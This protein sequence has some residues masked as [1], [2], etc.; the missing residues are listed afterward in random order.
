MLTVGVAGLGRISEQHIKTLAFIDNVKLVAVFDIRKKQVET[1]SRKL[2]VPGYTDIH[3]FF[4]SNL[5]DAVLILTPPETH[6]EIVCEATKRKKAIFCEKPIAHTTEEAEEIASMVESANVPFQCGFTERFNRGYQI[7]HKAV[8]DSLCGQIQCIRTTR[9]VAK[10]VIFDGWIKDP[11]RG[12]GPIIECIIHDIDLSCWMLHD[13]PVEVFASTSEEY[14][15]DASDAQVMMKFSKGAIACFSSSWKLSKSA[16][17]RSTMELLGSKGRLQIT[18][19]SQ[20]WVDIQSDT[21]VSSLYPITN[22]EEYPD[23]KSSPYVLD[24]G[25]MDPIVGAYAQQ[26][27]A[28]Y[29]HVILSEPSQSTVRD[30]VRALQFAIAAHTSVQIGEKIYIGQ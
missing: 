26:F 7:M 10:H 1:W 16:T 21:N 12:G 14:G 30:A 2:S 29:R 24:I 20:G 18:N 23:I 17:F 15:V 6:K 25:H 19:P 9:D 22:G 8:K 5:F 4:D 28:F 13:N 27:R 11:L 3:L